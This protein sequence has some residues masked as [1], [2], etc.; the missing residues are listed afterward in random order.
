[1]APSP[2]SPPRPPVWVAVR[3]WRS[4]RCTSVPT[5]R[6]CALA[7]S[8]ASTTICN[9]A[10]VGTRAPLGVHLL[11]QEG[12][13]GGHHVGRGRHKLGPGPAEAEADGGGG[14]GL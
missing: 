4:R 5:W 11:V 8:W 9:S 14:T 3:T 10:A 2:S 1:M 7:R 12:E 6:S 13:R